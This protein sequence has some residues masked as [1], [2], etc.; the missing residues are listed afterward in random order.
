MKGNE[1]NVEILQLRTSSLEEEVYA[2]LRVRILRGDLIPGDPLVEAQLSARFGISKT[3]VREALIRLKRDGLVESPQHRVTRVATP[4]AT[5]VREACEVREW[6]ETQLAIKHATNCSEE[7]LGQLRTSISDAEKA[8]KAD[9]EHGYIDALRSFSDILVEASGNR[10]AAQVLERLRNVLAL[11]GNVSRS[12]PGRRERSIDEHHAIYDAI[13]AK[14]PEA[15]AAATSRH[16]HSIVHDSLE[17]LSQF[18]A[19]VA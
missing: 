1:R 17:G 19:R 6:I 8:L 3:P 4:T 12:A 16:L 11:I 18:S 10:Y 13:A 2:A 5:D 15:A 14:D 9:D 7:V